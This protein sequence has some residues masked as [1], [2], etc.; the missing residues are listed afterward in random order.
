M[1]GDFAQRRGVAVVADRFVVVGAVEGGAMDVDGFVL[2]AELD[3]GMAWELF[4]RQ[5]G[6]V[7]G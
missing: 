7:P 1:D 6:K 2:E 3:V 4:R 5:T